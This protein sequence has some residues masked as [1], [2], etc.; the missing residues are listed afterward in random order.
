MEIVQMLCP[1]SKYS[2]KAPYGMTPQGITLHNTANDASAKNEVSYMITNNNKV[3]YHY[4]VDENRAVQ[5]IPLDRNAWHAGDGGGFG[6][7]Q[8]IGIEICYSKSGGDRFHQAERNAAELTARLMLQYGWGADRVATR[9]IN[10]HQSRSGKYCPHRTLD[11]GI[12]RLWNMIREEYARLSGQPMPTPA[13]TPTPAP[14][15]DAYLIQVTTGALNIR[16]GAGTNTEI[17]GCIR[18]KG[19]YT[20]VETNGNWGRLKSG[21]GWICLDYTK[22]IDGGST[23]TPA[24]ATT[25]RSVGDVVTINGVYSTSMS[26]N[27]LNPAVTTG[28]IT[29]IVNGANNPYLLNNGNIGWVNEGCIVGGSTPAPT[30]SSS[31]RKVGEVVSINGVYTSSTSTNKL[32]PAVKSGTITHIESGARNP[33]LLNNGNIGWVNESCIVGGGGS[34]S[35]T[36]TGSFSKGQRVTLKTSA[37]TYCT[38]QKIPSSVKGKSYTIMQVGQGSTHSDGVLLQEIMSWVYKKDVQ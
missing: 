6:N 12:D 35:S 31:G 27:K 26:T 15:G 19:C 10:T 2:I 21:A 38:G 34:S 25:G 29:K 18:D 36:S 9:T 8:T 24:P 3:S 5:G 4:A 32:N 20:I 23:P 11:E 30:P 1:S 28:T 37:S 7:R 13:P 17:T 22:R 16:S 14:S 33:Y